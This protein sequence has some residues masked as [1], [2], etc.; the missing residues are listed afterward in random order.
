MQKIIRLNKLQQV[1]VADVADKQRIII[2]N[3]VC[4]YESV[5]LSDFFMGV[6]MKIKKKLTVFLLAIISMFAVF[7]FS[8]CSSI[9]VDG[10][11]LKNPTKIELPRVWLYYYMGDI[12]NRKEIETVMSY[13]NGAEFVLSDEELTEADG[14]V[15]F[16][17]LVWISFGEDKYYVSVAENGRAECTFNDKHYITAEG[18]VDYTGLNDYVDKKI[19]EYFDRIKYDIPPS[20]LCHSAECFFV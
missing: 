19:Q 7:C 1:F 15:N 4:R 14:N 17:E 6:V 8:G 18:T 16:E 20:G 3:R 5:C 11:K 2:Y 13:F 9:T 12:T 10:K